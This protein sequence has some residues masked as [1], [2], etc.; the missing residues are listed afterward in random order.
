MAQAV[1]CIARTPTRTARL[2]AELTCA[3]VS[4]SA[5]SILAPD[6][7]GQDAI[8]P[9]IQA[10]ALESAA[11]SEDEG[12]VSGTGGLAGGV[13][14]LLAGMGLLSLPGLGLFMAAGP[15]VGALSGAALGVAIGRVAAA[16]IRMGLPEQEARRYEDRLKEGNTLVSVQTR[17]SA[18][19]RCVMQILASAEAEEVFGIV[20]P[21]PMG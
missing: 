21:H 8:L 12:L 5:I 13:F 1:I 19:A 7:P 18:Q 20:P 17:G 15:I 6:R 16:L 9:A 14:G 10:A 4:S 3:G 2:V 11:S